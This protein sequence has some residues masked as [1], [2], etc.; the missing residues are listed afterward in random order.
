MKYLLKYEISFPNTQV[1]EGSPAEAAGLRE[2]DR[3]IEI[4]DE[5]L[6]KSNHKEVVQKIKS[7]ENETIMLVLDPDAEKYYLDKG[8]TVTHSMENVKRIEC[9][10][11]APNTGIL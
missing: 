11:S 8:I 10:E 5:S 7:R 3:I 6:G 4:N 1:D 9:P 2:G